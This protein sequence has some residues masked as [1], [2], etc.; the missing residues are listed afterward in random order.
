MSAAG[1]PPSSM[2]WSASKQVTVT[3]LA[4]VGIGVAITGVHKGSDV[5]IGNWL[6]GCGLIVILGYWAIALAVAWYRAIS[7]EMQVASTPVPTPAEIAAL[8]EDEWGR[9][10][11]IVEVAA[12]HQMLTSRRN[13]ALI[14]SGLSL[15]CLWLMSENG[16]RR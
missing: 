12:V 8:L 7:A 4:S 15:G 9:A 16:R 3:G 6:I 13:E 10:P 11:T 14:A 5:T 1:D 2:S